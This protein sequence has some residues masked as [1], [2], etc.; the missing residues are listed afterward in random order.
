MGNP[1]YGEFTFSKSPERPTTKGY[2]RGGETKGQAKVSKVMSEF[3]SGDLHSGSSKAP[4][5]KNPKQAMAIAMSEKNAAGY[6][7]GGKAVKEAKLVGMKMEPEAIVKKEV[8]LLKKA[9]APAK[10]IKH[11]ETEAMPTGAL[12]GLKKG[13]KPKKYATGGDVMTEEMVQE[14]AKLFGSRQYIS[15]MEKQMKV[16]REAALQINNSSMSA[17]EKRDSLSAINQAQI[18][19]TRHIQ[20]V[21]KVLSE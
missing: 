16:M 19:M 7:K 20:S 21:K 6:K 9:G 10:I 4:L 5:V 11:E 17:Q 13:G 14:N 3:K 18:N 12:A 15:S 2:A 8:A 1:K